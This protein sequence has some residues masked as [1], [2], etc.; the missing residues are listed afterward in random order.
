M[1]MKNKIFLYST[2]FITTLLFSCQRNSFWDD[3][4]NSSSDIETQSNIMEIL[5]TLDNMDKFT[6]AV[7]ETGVD[8]ILNKD[9]LFTVFAFDNEQ[10]D[11]LPDGIKDS[12]EL[13]KMTIL[14]HVY[15]NKMLSDNIS[16][17]LY[18]TLAGKYSYLDVKGDSILINDKSLVVDKDILAINGVIHILNEPSIPAPNLYQLLNFDP[19]FEPFINYISNQ[20][21][22]V[23]DVDNSEI[24]GFNE[25]GNPIY[26]SVFIETNTFLEK[27]PIDSEDDQ[28]TMIVP[29]GIEQAIA[30][31]KEGVNFNG[32]VPDDYFIE[33]V[34]ETSLLNGVYKKDELNSG[35]LT[36]SGKNLS[37]DLIDLIEPDNQG[38][39]LS[40][41]RAFIVDGYSIPRE[42]VYAPVVINKQVMYSHAHKSSGVY[43]VGSDRIFW[44]PTN[45]RVQ[46]EKAYGEYVDFIFDTQMLPLDYKFIMD[47][48]PYGGGTIKIEVNGMVVQDSLSI[49]NT[50]E[51]DAHHDIEIGTVSF[52][53]VEPLEV[54]VTFV[55][56]HTKEGVPWS[57]YWNKQYML[58]NGM[59]FEPILE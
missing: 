55:E 8:S 31:V 49:E 10:Y 25:F 39:T 30:D 21:K 23:F 28:F 38:K 1:T 54:R 36:V 52:T 16:E 37:Q 45:W 48:R 41:G 15:Y 44:I 56:K 17:G 34:M 14:F 50:S 6:S 46:P 19:E 59:R 57:N 20:K 11:K 9:Q 29:T 7:K 51:E 33:P 42:V 12:P 35:L 47:L 40:N 3:H 13:L 24:I 4:Y 43:K 26:D 27:Y 22:V 58:S 32:E 18:K 53:K 5:E 2:I